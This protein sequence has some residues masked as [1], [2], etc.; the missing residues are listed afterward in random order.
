[1]LAIGTKKP[2]IVNLLINKG[3][4]VFIP[5]RKCCQPSNI[6]RP[7][8]IEAARNGNLESFKLLLNA[9]CDISEPGMVY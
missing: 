6:K 8:I 3:A 7:F 4:N 5:P 2:Q 9:G 1:M